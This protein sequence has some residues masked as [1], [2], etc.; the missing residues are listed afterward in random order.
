MMTAIKKKSDL[1][2][3]VKL[4]RFFTGIITLFYASDKLQT[5]YRYLSLLFFLFILE[6]QFSKCT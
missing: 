3:G 2:M 5:E 4:V 6:C 1:L